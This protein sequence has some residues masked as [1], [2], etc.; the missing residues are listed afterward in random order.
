MSTVKLKGVT[1]AERNKDWYK[2]RKIDQ[3]NRAAFNAA[4]RA[5]H[6]PMSHYLNEMGTDRF[7]FPDVSIVM[8]G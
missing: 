6:D 7:D 2:K 3:R 5:V 1:F 8:G 4:Y